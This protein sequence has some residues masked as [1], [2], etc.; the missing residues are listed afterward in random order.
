MESGGPARPLLIKPER[1]NRLIQCRKKTSLAE[2][3]IA[4]SLP[5]QAFQP[6]IQR[7]LQF[8]ALRPPDL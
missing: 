6:M 2:E 4:P 3:G 1:S 7:T 5:L 8:Q